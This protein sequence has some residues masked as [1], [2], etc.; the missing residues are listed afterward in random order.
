MAARLR[1]V[2]AAQLCNRSEWRVSV[3][4][5]LRSTAVQTLPLNICLLPCARHTGGAPRGH[6]ERG[7]IVLA[8]VC[9]AASA[10]RRCYPIRRCA[11]KIAAADLQSFV[12]CQ[13]TPPSPPQKPFSSYESSSPFTA[14]A[15][16]NPSSSSSFSSSSSSPRASA[17]SCSH[18]LSQL[19][20]SRISGGFTV[21][22]RDRG[23]SPS[24]T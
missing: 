4:K 17:A 8:A 3:L 5:S 22:R 7:R 13:K 16:N 20:E 10:Q 2:T 6:A 15:L 18:D 9:W 24:G 11:L 14:W 12:D 23:E 19:R 1:Q 21:A